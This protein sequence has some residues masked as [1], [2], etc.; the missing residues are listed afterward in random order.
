[1]CIKNSSDQEKCLKPKP[2]RIRSSQQWQSNKKSDKLLLLFVGSVRLREGSS[3]LF[4][5]KSN[6]C[7]SPL[8]LDLGLGIWDWGLGL[9]NCTFPLDRRGSTYNN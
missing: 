3:R 8:D 2:F 1:M 6:V 9:D 7:V 5:W 4:R